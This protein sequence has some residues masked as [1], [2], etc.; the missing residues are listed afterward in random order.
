M[1]GV[2][3]LLFSGTVSYIASAC[4]D[5]QELAVRPSTSKTREIFSTVVYFFLHRVEEYR[6]GDENEELSKTAGELLDNANDPKFANSKVLNPFLLVE[7]FNF[8]ASLKRPRKSRKLGWKVFL[9]N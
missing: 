1:Q 9:S 7:N 3:T 4:T 8:R 2:V 5:F 6:L